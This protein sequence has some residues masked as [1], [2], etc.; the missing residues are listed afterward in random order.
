MRTFFITLIVVALFAAAGWFGYQEYQ[1]RTEAAAQP[2]YEATTIEPGRIASTVSAVGNIAPAAEVSLTVRN[3]GFV[4]AVHVTEG[5]TVTAGQRLAEMESTELVLALAQAEAAR[6]I[7]AAQLAKLQTPPSEDQIAAAQG[8]VQVAQTGLDAANAAVSSAQAT[9]QELL[10]PIS[11]DQVA[12]NEAQVRQAQAEV[13]AAQQAYNEVRFLPNVGALPQAARLEQATIALE[14]AQAQAAL[15]Q[16]PPGD[17]QISAA[18]NTIAQAEAA[19][20]QAQGTLLTAENDLDRLLAGPDENDLRVARAQLRQAELNVMSAE[21]N[22]R[23]VELVAPIDATVTQVHVRADE[24]A[25]NALPAFVL[26]DLSSFHMDVM[27]DEID[28]HALEPEQ[29]V[30]ISIDALPDADVTGRVHTIAPTSIDV[31]GVIAYAVTIDLDQAS[32]NLGAELR[33]GMSATAIVTTAL[34]EDVLLA[35]NRFIQLDRENGRAYVYKME[36]GEP[37]LQEV[38]LGLRNEEVSEILSGLAAGDEL[39]LVTQSSEERLRGAI[40]G[41]E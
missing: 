8:A 19:Q 13:K 14:S 12:V 24:L 29:P 1:R 38:E 31:N 25:S 37:T 30:R 18:L 36:A 5:D 4:E 39:A 23:H 41:G 6:E 22:L 15:V 17:A 34:V 32:G 26:T 10:A 11:D 35:P 21:N 3:P 33:A 28:V 16:E 20:E 7:S 40:F 27:V 9:Y 2:Q